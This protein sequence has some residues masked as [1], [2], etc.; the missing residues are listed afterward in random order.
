MN[1]CPLNI[2]S[3]YTFISSTLKVEDIFKICEKNNYP[4]FGLC[5][6]LNMHAYGDIIALQNKYKV[7]P[8]YGATIKY[9]VNDEHPLLV[10]L[11][12]TSEI[13]YRNLIKIISLYPEGI[14]SKEFTL[15]K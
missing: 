8:I 14:T 2:Y 11:Y 4:Y 10:C 3:G 6:E 13:S 5:D 15:L 1:Y 7:K 12:C 9:L